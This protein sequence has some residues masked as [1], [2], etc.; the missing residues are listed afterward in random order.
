M[1][2]AWY[3]PMLAAALGGAPGSS[4]A[5]RRVG[6]FVMGLGIT[7]KQYAV[8]L[9][10]AL[11][12]GSRAPGRSAA[13]H[14]RGRRRRRAAV[15][16]V[17]LRPFAERV[18]DFH[19]GHPIRDDGVTLQAAVLDRFGTELPRGPMLAAGLLLIGLVA[20]RAPSR[21]SRRPSGWR[22]AS[23][24]FACSSRRRSSTIS[25]CARYLMLLGMAGWFAH[26]ETISPPV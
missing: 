14:R 9:L 17:A 3:E 2:L 15:L 1:E 8:V 23:S 24:S 4:P 25:T 19:V 7:G 21:A 5:G 6:Y 18:I 22:R 20:W 10:P 12:K 16:P 11:W 13:G 26:D